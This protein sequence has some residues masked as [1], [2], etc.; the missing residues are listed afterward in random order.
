MLGA[1]LVLPVRTPL[2]G[3]ATIDAFW[4][5]QSYA[6]P[7]ASG[8]EIARIEKDDR[9]R[10]IVDVGKWLTGYTRI[11]GGA[12][13][14]HLSSENFMAS[15]AAIEERRLNGRLAARAAAELWSFG[16]DSFWTHDVAF[17]WRSTTE[18]MDNAWVV[19]AGDSWASGGAPRALW[20]GAG[21]GQGRPMLLRAHPL[22]TDD[23][24]TS[25][26][27]GRH[28]AYG[29]TEFERP[30][31]RVRTGMIGYAFFADAARAWHGLDVTR[32]P[33]ELDLGVGL[34]IRLPENNGSVRVDLARGTRDGHMAFSVG[35]TP[36]AWLNFKRGMG[37]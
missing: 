16:G 33:F 2:G 11:E 4:D 7:I 13:F 25:Q 1:T 23:V 14:D 27:F 35:W 26:T 3:V 22:L 34:R 6:I 8:S 12:G 17:W 21:T 5:A 31:R 32:S 19:F 10:A 20:M 28:L 9:A 29:T 37:R 36:T 18:L 15:H 24:V 30:I